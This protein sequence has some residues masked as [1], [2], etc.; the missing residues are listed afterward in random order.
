MVVL[1][2]RGSVFRFELGYAVTSHSSQGLTAERV[3]VNADTGVHLDLL[4]F[5]FGQ[6]SI[7]RASHD[8]TL[9]ADK[10]TKLE[11]QLSADVSKT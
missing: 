5:R 8:S 10:M 1:H 3:P 4:N 11:P 9:F 7:S 6:V 2:S